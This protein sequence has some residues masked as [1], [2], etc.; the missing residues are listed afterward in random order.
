MTNRMEQLRKI[1]AE[2]S[3]LPIAEV[4][5]DSDVFQDLDLDSLCFL[6]VLVEIERVFGVKLN[7]ADIDRSAVNTPVKM[8]SVVDARAGKAQ[9]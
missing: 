9:A 8:M 7:P 4:K 6:E 2:K 5:D 3:L 1:L